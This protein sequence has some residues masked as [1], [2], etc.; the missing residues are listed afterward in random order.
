MNSP[1]AVAEFTSSLFATCLSTLHMQLHPSFSCR[2]M[3]SV[4]T[5]LGGNRNQPGFGAVSQHH[6]KSS[7]SSPVMKRHHG[8][9][10]H[11]A[12]SIWQNL[13]ILY[14][15]HERI[16]KSK[17]LV[18]FLTADFCEL[19]A[20]FCSISFLHN[21][22]QHC[23]VMYTESCTE[24]WHYSRAGQVRLQRNQCSEAEHFIAVGSVVIFY[25]LG[26]H[27]GQLFWHWLMWVNHGY[28]GRDRVVY[29][30]LPSAWRRKKNQ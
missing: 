8:S 11:T 28:W 9:S 22:E 24:L 30:L 14:C 17:V 12:A 4:Q 19:H 6:L 10:K 20:P 7:S 18:L 23:R 1:W 2:C 25:S 13:A 15:W 5:I 3:D 27:L 29:K 26:C 16:C 21:P